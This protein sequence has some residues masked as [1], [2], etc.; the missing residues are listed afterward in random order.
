MDKTPSAP[1]ET[2]TSAA[3]SAGITGSLRGLGNRFGVLGRML[4]RLASGTTLLRGDLLRLARRL[5]LL[6]LIGA[7]LAH[8]YCLE[9][10]QSPHGLFSGASVA[11]RERKCSHAVCAD[12]DPALFKFPALQQVRLGRLVERQLAEHPITHAEDNQGQLDLGDDL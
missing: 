8:V 10:H 2:S 1:A 11:A 6:T 9:D 5:E 12:D 4:L 7:R 3:R